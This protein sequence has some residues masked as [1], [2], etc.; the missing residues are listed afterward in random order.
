MTEFRTGQHVRVT[1][2]ATYA[3]RDRTD[4]WHQVVVNRL[5]RDDMWCSVPPDATIE[6]VEDLQLGD[7]YRT[8]DGK[9]VAHLPGRDGYG[10]PWIEISAPMQWWMTDDEVQRPLTLLVRDGKPVQP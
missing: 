2:E 8:D 5:G 3:V 6:P 4:D 10:K 7:V 9:T 1:Y